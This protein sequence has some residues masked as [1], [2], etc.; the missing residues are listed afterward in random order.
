[1]I[2]I[3]Q[4]PSSASLRDTVLSMMRLNE[5]STLVAFFNNRPRQVCMNQDDT[6]AG[7]SEICGEGSSF[8]AGVSA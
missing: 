8:A 3:D 6:A 5:R 4:L 7:V 1:V 2:N